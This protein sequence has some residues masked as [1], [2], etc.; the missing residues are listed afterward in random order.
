ML[1]EVA[2]DFCLSIAKP[3]VA[4]LLSETRKAIGQLFQT[5]HTSNLVSYRGFG[6]EY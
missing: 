5:D 1:S 6:N 2:V 4:Y 3:P